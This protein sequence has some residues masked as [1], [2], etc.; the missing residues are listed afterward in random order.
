MLILSFGGE[1]QFSACWGNLILDEVVGNVFSGYA[2]FF[3]LS[4]NTYRK[5]SMW[6]F[7]WYSLLVSWVWIWREGGSCET[8]LQIKKEKKIFPWENC[9]PPGAWL[10]IP[11]CRLHMRVS[12]ILHLVAFVGAGDQEGTRFHQSSKNVCK[13]PK[14]I[15]RSCRDLRQRLF[16]YT[17]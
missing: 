16:L 3:F 6:V 11:R 9:Y 2:F 1:N 4:I 10:S 14:S 12:R 17:I 13:S 8:L 7:N 5:A 15:C